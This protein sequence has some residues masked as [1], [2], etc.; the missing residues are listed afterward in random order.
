MEPD[1]HQ[2]MP[3][4][5]PPLH[6]ILPPPM[7]VLLLFSLLSLRKGAAARVI[8]RRREEAGE[9]INRRRVRCGRRGSAMRCFGLASSLARCS[10]LSWKAGAMDEEAVAAI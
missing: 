4:P 6:P 1:Y 8:I 3:L 7:H 10:L 9:R 2:S 5:W